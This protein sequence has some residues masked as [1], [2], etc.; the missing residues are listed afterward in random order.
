MWLNFFG[1]SKNFFLCVWKFEWE[2]GIGETSFSVENRSK[3][4]VTIQI[5]METIQINMETIQINMVT[6]QINMVTI[7]I[8]MMALSA[9]KPLGRQ[10]GD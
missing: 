3:Y 2:R 5:N 6:I 9:L 10:Y 1:S 7:Q 4:M 8:N